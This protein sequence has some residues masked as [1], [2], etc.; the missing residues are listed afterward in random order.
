VERNCSVCHAVGAR[1]A[2]RNPEAPPFRELH[3]RYPVETLA[4]AL[5]EG[6]LV[7]HPAMPQFK[8]Q[9]REIEDIITYLK[10]VQTRGSAK[11]GRRASEPAGHQG[12]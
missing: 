3:T 1:G 8:F 2:S 5:A 11:V 12:A 7:G 6:I 10:R 9:P 4:E